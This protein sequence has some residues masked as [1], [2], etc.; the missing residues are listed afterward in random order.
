MNKRTRRD[1]GF[2]TGPHGKRRRGA[3]G[4]VLRGPRTV[5]ARR[6][7][8]IALQNLRTG[9]L[10]GIENKYLDSW[11]GATVISTSSA[12]ANGVVSPTGGCTGCLSAP[13]QGDGPSSRDGRKIV[14]KSTFIQGTIDVNESTGQTTADSI[15]MIYV[16]LVQDMQTNATTMNSEDCF[17][18]PAANTLLAANPVRNMSNT[19]RFR[20][21]RKWCR[22]LPVL[23]MANQSSAAGGLVIAGC[24]VAFK[25]NWKG[26]IPVNF[27]TGGTTANVNTVVDNSLH[28]VAFA[29]DASL[30]PSISYVSRI[31]YVG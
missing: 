30:Q 27:T 2:R 13:A 23:S 19:S 29:S 31:R 6:G 18:N 9:G 26:V 28:I 17:A 21:L 5:S 12:A 8:S 3:Q 22:R 14:I 25:L 20:V 16:A 11:A 24:Q 1:A 4:L 7:R 10:L 15:P